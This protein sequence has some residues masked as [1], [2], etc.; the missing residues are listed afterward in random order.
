MKTLA[1]LLLIVSKTLATLLIVASLTVNICFFAGCKTLH[2]SVFGSP[3]KFA[4]QTREPSGKADSKVELVHIASLL[5]IKTHGKS[6]SDLVSDICYK[7][8][9]STDVPTVYNASLFEKMVKDVNPNEGKAMREYQRFISSLQGKRVI[10][11]EPE[12]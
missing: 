8:D 6:T 10:V 11:I 1:A 12:E 7:L 2:D 3:C 9:R 5:D 4:E